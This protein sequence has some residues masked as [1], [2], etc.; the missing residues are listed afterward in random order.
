M[1]IREVKWIHVALRKNEAPF[2][3]LLRA[4]QAVDFG[5]WNVVPLLNLR[6]K[7]SDTGAVI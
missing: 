1:E 5:L 3:H 7:L 6:V 4:I 2:A